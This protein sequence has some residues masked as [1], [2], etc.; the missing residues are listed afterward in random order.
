[1]IILVVGN[2]KVKTNLKILKFCKKKLSSCV[3]FKFLLR[4]SI[5]VVK[6]IRPLE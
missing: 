6:Q 2:P 1:M 4:T 3:E 5:N